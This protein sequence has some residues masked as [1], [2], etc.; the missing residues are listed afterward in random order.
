MNYISRKRKYVNNADGYFFCNW[1]VLIAQA[2]NVKYIADIKFE[3][4]LYGL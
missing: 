4:N 1:N 2:Q 3:S